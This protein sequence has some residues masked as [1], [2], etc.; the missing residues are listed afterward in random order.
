MND[1]EPEVRMQKN[2]KLL[3]SHFLLHDGVIDLAEVCLVFREWG[4]GGVL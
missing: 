3:Q 2:G 4:G 1:K